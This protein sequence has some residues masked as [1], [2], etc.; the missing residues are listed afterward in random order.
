NSSHAYNPHHHQL[1]PFSDIPYDEE[2][3]NIQSGNGQIQLSG[4]NQIQRYHLRT[5]EPENN[6]ASNNPNSSVPTFIYAN[7]NDNYQHHHL[8]QAHSSSYPSSTIPQ[9]ILNQNQSNQQFSL[10]INPQ[11]NSFGYSFMTPNLVD[12][13]SNHISAYQN[14]SNQNS[15]SSGGEQTNFPL[16][17]RLGHNLHPGYHHIDQRNDLNSINLS[18]NDSVENK[19]MNA[20]FHNNKS[21][22]SM[23]NSESSAHR[24][25]PW[26]PKNIPS[27][28]LQESQANVPEQMKLGDNDG[29]IADYTEG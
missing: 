12:I 28:F 2:N 7:K 3:Y 26:S 24:S 18:S 20:S 11:S 29:F 5:N 25:N 14:S 4:V 1:I 15:T 13:Q 22:G 21:S 17:A 6:S 16:A 10:S 27:N 19:P 23:K 8:S 9:L